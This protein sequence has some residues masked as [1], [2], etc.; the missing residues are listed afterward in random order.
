MLPSSVTTKQLTNII[1]AETYEE[2]LKG[3]EA[4]QP[5]ILVKER[6]NERISAI[7]MNEH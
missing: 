3:I 4:N 5:G 6:Q 2:L 1:P 7:A